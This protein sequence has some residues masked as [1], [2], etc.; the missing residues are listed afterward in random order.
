MKTDKYGIGEKK[1]KVYLNLNKKILA[2]TS[3]KANEDA[4]KEYSS[5]ENKENILLYEDV[6]LENITIEFKKDEGKLFLCGEMEFNGEDFGW[7]DVDIP[8]EQELVIEIIEF[9]MKKLGKLKTVME[10]LK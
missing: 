7:M 6:K 8:I 9:Y 10:A 1:M 3:K 2:K 4:I 5:D